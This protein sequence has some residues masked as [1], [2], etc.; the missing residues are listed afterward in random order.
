[1]VADVRRCPQ[2][3]DERWLPACHSHTIILA[4]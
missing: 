2:E 4:V 3:R 1:V